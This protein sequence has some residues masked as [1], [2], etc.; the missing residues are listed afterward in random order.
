VECANTKFGSLA[1]AR[2]GG[3]SGRSSLSFKNSGCQASAY[4]HALEDLKRQKK[5]QANIYAWLYVIY[6]RAVFTMQT[7]I[8]F[9]GR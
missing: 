6:V 1:L 2:V 4:T 3:C 5:E 7:V 8:C 9:L